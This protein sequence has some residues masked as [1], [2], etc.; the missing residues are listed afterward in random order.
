MKR[1]QSLFTY[2]SGT[3]LDPDSVPL[4]PI[5]ELAG[6]CRVLIEN[7]FGIIA[8]SEECVCIKVKYGQLQICGCD[9]KL[10]H[11]SK[12]KLL[13]TGKINSIHISRREKS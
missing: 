2:L 11:M 3:S 1:K 9:L 10:Q 6:D 4:Y 7:H 5:V 8:Y 13:I 12:V